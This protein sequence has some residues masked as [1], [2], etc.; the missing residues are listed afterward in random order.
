LDNSK[1]EKDINE[2][3]RIIG[4]MSNFNI[5]DIK[6][7]IRQTIESLNQFFNTNFRDLNIN[8]TEDLLTLVRNETRDCADK[9]IYKQNEISIKE[10]KINESKSQ[11]LEFK[12]KRIKFE[13]AQN[14]L[15]YIINSFLEIYKK[16]YDSLNSSE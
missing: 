10:S 2:I 8:Y 13:E 14:Q 4:S 9:Q 3:N 16:D 5:E 15:N 1:I 7:E 12:L 11:M 6:A